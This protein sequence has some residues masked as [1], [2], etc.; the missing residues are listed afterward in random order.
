MTFENFILAV[1][2]LSSN[3]FKH[4]YEQVIK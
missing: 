3:E 2:L 4:T 1:L